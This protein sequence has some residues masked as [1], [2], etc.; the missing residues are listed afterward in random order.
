MYDIHRNT[1]GPLAMC[2][3]T[4][5]SHA[6]SI[7]FGIASDASEPSAGKCWGECNHVLNLIQFADLGLAFSH[8]AL[9]L[10]PSA[11]ADV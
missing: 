6:G 8:L 9:S 7:Q 2:S 1:S 10:L 5:S 4:I 3:S 11:C